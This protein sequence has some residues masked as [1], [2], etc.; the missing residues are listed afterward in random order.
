[1]GI[2]TSNL[3]TK[4]SNFGLKT[5]NFNILGEVMKY[6]LSIVLFLFANQSIASSLSLN[7]FIKL[8]SNQNRNLTIA[9]GK[10]TQAK[11]DA[12]AANSIFSLSFDLTPTFT[13]R[14]YE[15]PSNISYGQK[16][17]EIAPSLTQKL[18]TG[19]NISV[20]AGYDVS[21]R[22]DLSVNQ[23]NSTYTF[24]IEQSL[25]KNS[26][27]E[28]NFALANYRNVQAN[29]TSI[30]TKMMKQTECINAVLLYN[31]AYTSQATTE[32]ISLMFMQSKKVFNVAKRN[33]KKR[34]LSKINYLSAQADWLNM[35]DRAAKAVNEH[36][37]NRADISKW[38]ELDS[39][40]FVDPFKQANQELS[41]KQAKEHSFQ[42]K[43]ADNRVKEKASYYKYIK[44]KNKAEVNLFAK[45]GKENIAN[46]FSFSTTGDN[47][48]YY[49]KGGVQISLSIFDKSEDVE[50]ANA[51]I[52]TRI[53]EQERALEREKELITELQLAQNIEYLT[54]AIENGIEKIKIYKERTKAASRRLRSGKI[55]FQDYIAYRDSYLQEQISQFN[56]K[57]QFLEQKMK[58][59]SLSQTTPKFCEVK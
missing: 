27:G 47:E 20:G 49:I 6:Y 29:T 30:E 2:N 19:T 39:T 38:I 45:A 44:S 31:K 35:Q 17:Y 9:N 54:N 56:R 58:L 46:D 28:Q 48:N 11:Q 14:E 34:L 7:D 4:D 18:I 40:I 1:L 15:F 50:S 32:L 25:W 12:I 24:S 8:Y 53:A 3:S 16:N 42:S 57:H 10:N 13:K 36:N 51:L 33:Y 23:T 41:I 26:F 52:A 43:V 21:E 5:L 55:E 37:N 59:V 22:S